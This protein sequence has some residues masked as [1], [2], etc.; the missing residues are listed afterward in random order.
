M[1]IEEGVIR[2][3]LKDEADNTIRDLPNSSVERKPNSI[4]VL[5]FSQNKCD[6]YIVKL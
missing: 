4:L 6:T 2:Q 3:G 1:E 5:L